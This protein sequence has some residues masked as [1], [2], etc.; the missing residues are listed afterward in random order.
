MIIIK[1]RE[2][3]ALS[4]EIKKTKPKNRILRLLYKAAHLLE[5]LTGH[6]V[7]EELLIVPQAES[8]FLIR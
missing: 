3:L 6:K 2:Q 5:S 1:P 4:A 7:K 8:H